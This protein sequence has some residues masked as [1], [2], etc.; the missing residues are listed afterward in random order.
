MDDGRLIDAAGEVRLGVFS[1]PITAVNFRDYRLETPFGRPAGAWARR[2]G[3]NQFQFLGALSDRLA[4]GCAIAD[5]KLAGTAFVYFYDPAAERLAERSFR[6]PLARGISVDQ[7]PEHGRATLATSGGEIEMTAGSDPAFRR[8]RVRLAGGD[9][10]DATFDE[11]HLRDV[12]WKGSRALWKI[13]CC[14]F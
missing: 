10:I 3:F 4:I 11:A 2:F 7:D 12:H 9:A 1:K 8:L 14:T 6:L 5:I 13:F